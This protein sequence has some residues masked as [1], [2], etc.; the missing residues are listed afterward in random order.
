MDNKKGKAGTYANFSKTQN[1]AKLSESR[2]LDEMGRK[3]SEMKTKRKD[4]SKAEE[5]AKTL[6]NEAMKHEHEENFLKA[7][8]FY[9]EATR[10][11]PNIL[12]IYKK[13]G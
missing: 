4:S 5:K 8:K 10:L 13:R 9:Q 3:S 1:K 12:N 7:I 11:C 6:L 2:K